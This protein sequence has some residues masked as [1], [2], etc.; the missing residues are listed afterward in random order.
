MPRGEVYRVSL[1]LRPFAYSQ[2]FRQFPHLLVFVNKLETPIDQ[3]RYRL[4][5]KVYDIQPVARF[6]TGLL[7]EILIEG[8]E[9]SREAIWK[10]IEQR[11]VG[12]MAQNF[13]GVEWVKIDKK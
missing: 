10:Y 11:V 5:L 4:Q 1:L 8:D 7:N 3:Y 6:V 2:L 12:G 9:L 13:G